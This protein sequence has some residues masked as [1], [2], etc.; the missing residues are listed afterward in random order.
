M[1][2]TR[3]WCSSKYHILLQGSYHIYLEQQCQFDK[4]NVK[5]K[6][7]G[8]IWKLKY[9]EATHSTSADLDLTYKLRT[10]NHLKWFCK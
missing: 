5:P 1:T 4:V 6:I 8:I 10:I 3:I 2:F 7:S 9:F